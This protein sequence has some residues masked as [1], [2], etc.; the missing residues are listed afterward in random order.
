MKLKIDKKFY[1]LIIEGKKR[2]EIRKLN[3]NYIEPGQKVLLVDLE[4]NKLS[5]ITI[6][7]KTKMSYIDVV[8]LLKSESD[9]KSLEFVLNNYNDEK[10]LLVF[11]FKVI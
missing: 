10:Y 11:E 7:R 4:G 3:K 8:N 6:T 2:L 5:H 1:N 9:F